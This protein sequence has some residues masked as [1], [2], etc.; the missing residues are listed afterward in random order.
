MAVEVVPFFKF[1]REDRQIPVE[2]EAEPIGVV[3]RLIFA[4]ETIRLS[5]SGIGNRH[6]GGQVAQRR[7]RCEITGEL[8]AILLHCL[9]L[10]IQIQTVKQPWGSLTS[11]A[12]RWCRLV[13][14]WVCTSAT[15][16]RSRQ[17]TLWAC[18]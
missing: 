10:R 3:N 1:G 17:T 18:S 6:R 11:G 16:R 8:K 14:W 9:S 4:R 5:K 12:R 7:F 2:D 13:D 15:A